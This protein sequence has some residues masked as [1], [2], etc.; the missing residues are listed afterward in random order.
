MITAEVICDSVSA[1]G[2]RITSM[3]LEYPRMVHSEL[4]THR[5]FSRS[6]SSSRAIPVT[7]IIQRVMDDPA[8]P[9]A[10]G[11]NQRGMQAGEE[12]TGDVRKKAI[13]IWLSARDAAVA[14]AEQLIELGLA[15]QV[16][17]RILEPF[18]HIRVI[19]TAT[20][21][22]NF[23][24][25]RCHPAADPTMQLLALTMNEALF[26]STPKRLRDSEWHLP[27]VTAVERQ[28]IDW[29]DD[30]DDTGHLPLETAIK[31]S[32]A[33]CARVSYAKHGTENIDH[34]ADVDLY[35]KLLASGHMSP[36]EHQAFPLF[37]A[38]EKSANFTGWF[39]YRKRLPHESVYQP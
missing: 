2:A 19:V 27:Y 3:Q 35:D 28:Q 22:T 31:Y 15:K 10:W 36:F 16:V 12:V 37:N 17:N 38:H 34:I 7:K 18:A 23:F 5:L 1:A 25:L 39:Q 29:Y 6:A 24:N 21:W 13:D 20:D 14:H 11:L 9:V 33:R 30:G 26:A 4:M 8:M 32:V